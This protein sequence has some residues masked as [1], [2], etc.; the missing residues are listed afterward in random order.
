MRYMTTPRFRLLAVGFTA[1]TLLLA[2]CGDDSTTSDTA[3]GSPTGA[4]SLD[5]TRWTAT[6]AEGIT[7]VA[8]STV[9]LT[10]ADGNV[11]VNGGCNTIGGGYTIEDDILKVDQLA[12]TQMAC[13]PELMA[14]DEAMSAFLASGPTVEQSAEQLVLTSGANSVTFAAKA[15]PELEGTTWKITGTIENDGVSSVPEGGELTIADGTVT[16]NAGCNTGSGSVEVGDG[17][18]TFG[19]IATTKMMCE[20]DAMALET[21]VLTVLDGETTYT[22]EGDTLRIMKGDVGLDLTAAT[23]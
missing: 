19:P 6:S 15:T 17:T 22:I 5:G 9:L 14:Q 4:S 13:A 8:D 18:L 10:F 2:A 16:L 11:G 3:A 7:L 1:A 21:T 12:S 23:M 20:D